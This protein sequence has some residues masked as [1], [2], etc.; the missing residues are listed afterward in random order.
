MAIKQVGFETSV[1]T[2]ANKRKN[3]GNYLAELVITGLKAKTAHDTTED[4]LKKERKILSKQEEHD[5]KQDDL[6]KINDWKVRWDAR[7][8]EVNYNNSRYEEQQAYYDEFKKNN[9]L[10]TSTEYGKNKFSGLDNL[11][12]SFLNTSMNNQ[13]KVDFDVMKEQHIPY[14][15]T[16]EDVELFVESGR[17]ID[18]TLRKS[19]VL[20]LHGKWAF[21]KTDWT[22]YHGFQKNEIMEN[23]PLIK[24][25]KDP[26]YKKNFMKQVNLIDRITT[27]QK[28]E[29]KQIKQVLQYLEQGKTYEL[30]SLYGK[31]IDSLDNQ[32]KV[33]ETKIKELVKDTIHSSYAANPVLGFNLATKS[34]MRIEPLEEQMKAV[35][36]GSINN[37]AQII[38]LNNLYNQGVELGYDF[39]NETDIFMEEVKMYQSNFPLEKNDGTPLDPNNEEDAKQIIAIQN[40]SFKAVIQG[41]GRKTPDLNNKAKMSILNDLDIEAEDSVTQLAIQ[42]ADRVY[43]YSGGGTQ[44]YKAIIAKQ[45]EL[46]E[47]KSVNDIPNLGRYIKEDE[48]DEVVS[49]MEGIGREDISFTYVGKNIDSGDNFQISYKDNIGEEHSTFVSGEELDRLKDDLTEDYFINLENL[50]DDEAEVVLAGGRTN[51]MFDLFIEQFSDDIKQTEKVTDKISKT[52]L[53]TLSFTGALFKDV[54]EPAKPYYEPVLD[55]L[56][57]YFKDVET[58]KGL[59][60]EGEQALVP[61]I[62]PTEAISARELKKQSVKIARNMIVSRNIFKNTKNIDTKYFNEVK[63]IYKKAKTNK[64]ITPSMVKKDVDKAYWKMTSE[65]MSK[66]FGSWFKHNEKN[67][68]SSIKEIQTK[69]MLDS[70]GSKNLSFKNVTFD[71]LSDIAKSKTR[72]MYDYTVSR[73]RGKVKFKGKTLNTNATDKEKFEYI[74]EIKEA[75]DK[76]YSDLNPKDYDQVEEYLNNSLMLLSKGN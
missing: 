10:E 69:R 74:K 17:T 52:G 21:E 18:N 25:I 46:L 41:Q 32:G 61:L 22:K 2:G 65:K 11:E 8:N 30:M 12:N 33:R 47:K 27:A 43:K 5:L 49:M 73:S 7:K 14:L 15:K 54:S 50:E 42:N 39:A 38:K 75:L 1:F 9:Q 16:E 35:K 64:D 44:A 37:P 51:R 40:A 55:Y 59:E 31:K 76:K 13:N 70:I 24:E 63:S 29:K 67:L 66:R 20:K 26:S 60:L 34:G 72:L 62:T 6:L 3:A 48:Y 45:Y 71:D 36:S 57:S 58:P 28:N 53:D 68:N 23:F 19:D 4:R 56:S